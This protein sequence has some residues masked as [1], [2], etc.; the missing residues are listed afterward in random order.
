MSEKPTW[1][2]FATHS[3][4]KVYDW[5]E[6]REPEL[7]TFWDGYRY[8]AE[9]RFAWGEQKEDIVLVVENRNGEKRSIG[10][11]LVETFHVVDGSNSKEAV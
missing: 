10:Y 1:Y 3:H 5:L 8:H 4:Q 2:K 7:A 11:M 9:D 6:M